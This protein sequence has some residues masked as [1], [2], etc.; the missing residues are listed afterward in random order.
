[1]NRAEVEQA[2]ADGS[3]VVHRRMNTPPMDT[4]WASQIER[5]TKGGMVI[6][7][8]LPTFKIKPTNLTLCRDSDR[9]LAFISRKYP[10][11]LTQRDRDKLNEFETATS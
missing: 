9:W 1:M 3:W 2:A 11:N 8:T 4:L 7:K 10:D 5:V 6:L